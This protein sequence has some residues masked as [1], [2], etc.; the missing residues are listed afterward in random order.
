MVSSGGDYGARVEGHGWG[1]SVCVEER[2]WLWLR[3]ECG[4]C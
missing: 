1:V 3:G 4:R 2:V